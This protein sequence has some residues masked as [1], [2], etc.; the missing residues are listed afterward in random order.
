[1]N[2]IVLKTTIDSLSKLANIPKAKS[3]E[4]CE[5]YSKLSDKDVIK[6]L[7]ILAYRFFRNN[8]ILL[9]YA[10]AAIR[11]INPEICPPVEEM[12]VM[13]DQI[14]AN[15]TEGNMA[16]DENHKLVNASLIKFTTLFNQAGIDYYIVGAIPCFLKTGAQLFRYHDD[17]DIMVNEEDLSK[18]AEIVELSG[19]LYHDD[20]FPSVERF[21]EME[22]HK[23]PHTVLAQNPDN[24]FHLGFFTFRREADKSITM[25][26]YSHRLEDGK[27]IVDLLERKDTPTGTS[28]RYDEE[29]TE[30]MG[31]SFKTS[32][33]ESIYELKQYT[34]RPKDVA[35]NERLSPYISQEKLSQLSLNPQTKVETQNIDN[36]NK[37]LGSPAQITL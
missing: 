29:S 30:Y 7:S 33:V 6:E 21:N 20:R 22:Q 34:G 12:M 32:T 35:D 28:L 27:V 23:P 15:E 11:N 37:D 24:E 17:I 10:C 3:T 2:L 8:D 5:K 26:E 18:V 4:L 9:S 14:Y 13:L 36:P 31:T 25:R 1:M 19:Y 16:L